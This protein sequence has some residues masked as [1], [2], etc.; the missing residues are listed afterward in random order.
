MY[1]LASCTYIHTF[2]RTHNVRTVYLSVCIGGS[3]VVE[4][5]D[6]GAAL[7]SIFP[8]SSIYIYFS[9][10]TPASSSVLSTYVYSNPSFALCPKPKSVRPSV[11]LFAWTGGRHRTQLGPGPPPSTQ[12]NACV[13]CLAPLASSTDI[14]TYYNHWKTDSLGL[15]MCQPP[16]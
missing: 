13:C 7:A 15:S 12:M 16:P 1:I 11:C 9:L 14:H 6:T 10:L 4:E 8:F 5:G 3:Q 2:I